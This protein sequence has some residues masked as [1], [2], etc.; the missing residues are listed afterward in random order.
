MKTI[1]IPLGKRSYPIWVQQGLFKQITHLLKP[2]NMGNKW[3]II[4][5]DKIKI[6]YGNELQKKLK[7]SGFNVKILSFILLITLALLKKSKSIPLGMIS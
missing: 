6:L 5:Q 7:N 4:T 2:M 3:F 1:S